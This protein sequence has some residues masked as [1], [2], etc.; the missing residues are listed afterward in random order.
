MKEKI[1][2]IICKYFQCV[3]FVEIYAVKCKNNKYLIKEDPICNRC[4]KK[5]TKYLATGLSRAE[6]LKHE[7][8]I[9]KSQNILN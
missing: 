1:R 7:W 5:H 9:V 2:K 8:F 6:L 3:S 4:G